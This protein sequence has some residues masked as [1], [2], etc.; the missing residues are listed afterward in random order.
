MGNLQ[1]LC[2]RVTQKNGGIEINFPLPAEQC[3]HINNIALTS[4]YKH[5]IRSTRFL[6]V[7]LSQD[8]DNT[9]RRVRRQ[10]HIWRSAQLAVSRAGDNYVSLVVGGAQWGFLVPRPRSGWLSEMSRELPC[11][12]I[13]ST[14]LC[15]LCHPGWPGWSLEMLLSQQQYH[16]SVPARYRVCRLTSLTLLGLLEPSNPVTQ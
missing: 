9:V 4:C 1:F 15:L 7:F 2:L 5:I 13:T 14:L 8:D 11:V 3:G 10:I 12:T 16:K 6:Y